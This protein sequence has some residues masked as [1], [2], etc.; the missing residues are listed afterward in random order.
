MKRSI[1]TFGLLLTSISAI[2]GS[3]WLFSAY[4]TAAIAGPAATLSW[5]IGGVFVVIVAFVFA[6]ICGMLPIT[7]SSTRIPQFTHGTLVSFMFAWMIWLSYLS[8]MATEVQAVIQYASFY[9]PALIKVNG[10][11]THQGYQAAMGL[12]L[13]VSLINTYSIRW[14]V[15]CNSAL[16]ILKVIIPL[17]VVGVI[18]FCYFTPEH[19]LH[20]GNSSFMPNGMKGVL[21]A[22]SSG[23]IVFAFNGF[24]QAAEMAGDA[25]NPGRSVPLAI[26]G[27]VAISLVLFLLIQF[28]FFS[29]LNISNITQ[30]WAHITLNH[31]NSPLAS[32]IQQ[33]HVNF[34]LPLLY[35][36]AIIAPLAAGLMYCSSAA[37]SLFA[38][39]KN[40]YLPSFFQKLTPQGNPMTAAWVNFFLGMCLFAPLPGW[41]SMVAFLT[42]LLAITYAVGPVSLLTLR[43]QAPNQPRPLRLPFVHFWAFLSFYICTLLAYW[44]GWDV[45]SKMGFAVLIGAVLVSLYR[46]FSKKAIHLNFRESL[47]M[48]PYFMGLIVV[49]YYGDYGGK[50]ILSL[51]ENLVLIAVFCAVILWIA[52]RFK[53]SAEETQAYIQSLHLESN[54]DDC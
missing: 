4:Y 53:L 18:L 17:V 51:T 37:R 29:S 30:G 38:M 40:G 8:L 50:G 39:S 1:S 6:E 15:R 7:G 28:S 46:L 12:M 19:V 26:V 21:G 5:L 27:S 11:L 48:W 31:D 45:L 16:T 25:K 42:S 10:G 3:G 33:D 43:T 20:P 52:N 22:I 41:N 9:W 54:R 14:L 23:G 32:I 13:L 2:I 36:G 49:S 44:S 24:K 35:V 34:L 47:W